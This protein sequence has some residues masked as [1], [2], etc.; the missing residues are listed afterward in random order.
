MIE[1]R[2]FLR[3]SIFTTLQT[4]FQRHIAWWQA[5]MLI[6]CLVVYRAGGVLNMIPTWVPHWNHMGMKIRQ[7]CMMY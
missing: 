2:G 3:E 1:E 4:K 7:E 5:G 6:T